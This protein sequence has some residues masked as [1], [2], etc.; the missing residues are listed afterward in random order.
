VDPNNLPAY[1]SL[2]TDFLEPPD[3]PPDDPPTEE[4]G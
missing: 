4:E 3:E 2:P 1:Q